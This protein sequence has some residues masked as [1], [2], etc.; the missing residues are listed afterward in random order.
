MGYRRVALLKLSDSYGQIAIY[1]NYKI[2]VLFV[3]NDMIVTTF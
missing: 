3:R 2:R 1:N